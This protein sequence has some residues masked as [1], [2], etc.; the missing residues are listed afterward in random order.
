MNINKFPLVYLFSLRING[1]FVS[2]VF[3]SILASVCNSK[4]PEFSKTST[5]IYYK[6]HK[7]GENVVK[8]QVD[9]F[10]TVNLVY[11]TLNDSV[12]FTG[13]RKLQLSKPAFKGAVDECFAMLSIG[14]SASFIISA[15]DFFNKTLHTSLPEFLPK[16]SNIKVVISVLDIQTK[17][18][19][20]KEKEKFLSWIEDFEDYEKLILTNFIEQK[21]IDVPPAKSGLYCIKLKEGYGKQVKIGDTVTVHYEGK[22]LNGTF[23]DSTKKHNQP[24]QFVYGHKWQVIDGL[25]K[26]IGMMTEGEKSLFI[27][28]SQLAFGKKGSSDGTIPPYTSVIFEVELLSVK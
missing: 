27:L 9:D 26:A 24:F 4:Y 25:N 15:D 14:D 21:D 13:R 11:K 17:E 19:F 2:L 23:F 22:F 12:F 3:I 7:I 1:I 20:V 8:P 18:E 5:G 16:N 6:L 10:I 28:P